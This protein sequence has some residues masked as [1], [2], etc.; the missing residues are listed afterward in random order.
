MPGVHPVTRASNVAV[1]AAE[2]HTG[3][4]LN[5][6]GHCHDGLAFGAFESLVGAAHCKLDF[7]GQHR[8]EPRNTAPS[9]LDHDVQALGAVETPGLSRAVPANCNWCYP[10]RSVMTGIT[11]SVPVVAVLDARPGD[12]S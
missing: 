9:Q 4:V 7:M 5:D 10:L 6:G 12:L 8:S 11:D 3:N 2:D 1:L